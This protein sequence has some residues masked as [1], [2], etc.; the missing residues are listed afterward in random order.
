MA[1]DRTA[2]RTTAAPDR[3]P[4]QPVVSTA[5]VNLRTGAAQSLQRRMGNHGAQVF[6][7]RALRTSK[8]ATLS[9]EEAER[10]AR[11]PA[12]MAAGGHAVQTFTS[13]SS[14]GDP[15]E[16]EAH[17]TARRV[18]QTAAPHHTGPSPRAPES[19]ATVHR[20]RAD[21]TIQCKADSQ[22]MVT[23]SLSADIVSSTGS[24]T[25]LPPRVREFMEPR[26]KADF[27]RVRIHTGDRAA[28][29]SKQL[30]A[31]AF[32][33]GNNIFFAKDQFRP[34][35]PDGQELLAHELTHTI[36]QGAA[37]QRSEA[38]DI[39]TTSPVRI[40]RFDFASPFNY[41][42]EKANLI[43]GFR[44]LTIV[45]GVNP[46]NMSRVDRSAANVL[47]ALVELLPGGGLITDALNNSGVFDKAGA[48]VEQ[49]LQTLGV[50]A[51]SI[52]QAVTQFIDS[53]SIADLANLGGVWERAKRIFTEPIERIV[54]FGKGL[55]NGIIKFV[56]DAILMPLARLAEGTRGWDLLIAV[57]GKNPITGDPVPRTPETLI[58]GFMKLIGQEDVWENMKKANAIPRAWAW[59][60]GAMQALMAFVGQIPMLAMNTF[61]SLE[62]ADIVLVPR[63]FAKVAAVFGNFIGSFI[64]WAGGAAWKLAEIVFDAVSPG[65]F[66]YIKRTG[67]ALKSILKNPLPF[68][69]NLVKAAKL[70]FENF[71]TNIV[72]HLKAGLIDWLTGSLA[73]VYIPKALSLVEL[74]KFALSVLGI[75]WAQI[76]GKIVK[77]LGPNGEKIM[78]GLE[79]TFD[80]VVA[81]VKGGPA[82]AWDLIKEKLTGLK[83]M[84]ISGITDFV[85]GTIVK[86]AIPKLIGMFIPGAGFI[87][88]I[89][90]IYDTIMVFVQKISKIIQVVTAFIDS[91]VSIAGGAI[92][93]A[94]KRVESVL[95]GLLSLAISFL[96]GFLGLGKVTDKIKEVIEKVRTTVD[97]A[98]DAVIAWIVGKAKAL[99]AKLF[100]KEGK[101]GKPDG[102]T[103]VEKERDVRAAVAKAEQIANAT[104]HDRRAVEK[105]LP[106]LQREFKLTRIELMSGENGK[107]VIRAEIN[108]FFSTPLDVA[109]EPAL[110]ALLISTGYFGSSPPDIDKIIKGVKTAGNGDAVFQFIKSGK[111]AAVSG[112][113][114]VL[115]QLKN[116]QM[117]HSVYMALDQASKIPTSLLARLKF[118]ETPPGGGDVDLVVISASGV[119]ILAY[120]FKGVTGLGNIKS[121]ADWAATQLTNVPTAAKKIV[122]IEVKNGTY[123]MFVSSANPALGHTGYM[124]GIAAFKAANPSVTLKVRFSDGTLKT[125]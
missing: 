9:K 78:Q 76:R 28:R 80:I 32:T 66:G 41:V 5:P 11:Q 70:G 49:Q 45:L 38:P 67:A 75:T 69:G 57:L 74:G 43:P 55:I 102:R 62:L 36:Q 26:F 122:S 84:V 42:A 107:V 19:A 2:V 63:A 39:T 50:A 15:A 97:K 25:P 96:A 10:A 35:S 37:I 72:D 95:S 14:P 51:G 54:N 6:I 90:S 71:A 56:K 58:G 121:G 109:D 115:R 119:W 91:I 125:F 24:G 3:R 1:Q 106:G 117:V 103:E 30:H 60:Q 21:A 87:P 59:F 27:S 64:Q 82:A 118:E 113:E 88:A 104:N 101:D 48:W 18:M 92:G 93:A 8:D 68:V 65:A 108:P 33:V 44:M 81:L 4:P 123:A 112:Y 110:R 124:G 46:V 13:V 16:R 22:P 116:P 86:K 53:L 89:I 79:T 34:D 20:Q 12:R 61:K 114:K 83:D 17:S 111:F 23:P 94:A 77:V 100:G 73:G 98:I 40:Q 47:R 120:Q 99:F 29:L 105:Q 52:K 31:Q 85:T 7:A